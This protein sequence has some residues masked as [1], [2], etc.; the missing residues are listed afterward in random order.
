MRRFWPFCNSAFR[1]DSADGPR[2]VLP[3]PIQPQQGRSH[4]AKRDKRE[5]NMRNQGQRVIGL[6]YCLVLLGPAGAAEWQPVT[7]ELLKKV[8]P[9]Y[10]GLS[11]VVVDHRNGN[12]YVDVSDQGIFRSADQGRTWKLLGKPFKGRTEWP[13]S[14]AID[15][16][17]TGKRLVVATVY[18]ALPSPLARRRAERGS[19]WLRVPV[20]LTGV[21]LDWGAEPRLLLAPEARVGWPAHCLARWRQDFS[22][23]R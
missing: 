5:D 12:V 20:T 13:G 17:G 23:R 6:V 8:K 22:R 15:P 16:V 18:A 3:S 9:G 21:A 4:P 2:L 7:A 1:D 10:G 11:G 14:L 19:S